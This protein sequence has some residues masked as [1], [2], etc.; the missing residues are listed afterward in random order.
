MATPRDDGERPEIVPGTL[1]MLILKALTIGPL[2]GYAVARRLETASEGVLRVEEGSL[3]PALHRMERRGWIAAEWGQSELNRRAK[4]YSL[5]REGRRE[6]AARGKR[7]Q[8][9]A[10]AIA[11]VLEAHAIRVELRA[12]AEL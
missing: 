10:G 4:Y 1:E 5:T 9:M 7:W 3:Y 2:H 6:L 12:G 11:R 8:R